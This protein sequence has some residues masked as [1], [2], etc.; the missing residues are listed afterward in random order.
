LRR[1]RR[2]VCSQVR[3]SAV[4]VAR[5]SRSGSPEAVVARAEKC[6]RYGV[7][8]EGVDGRCGKMR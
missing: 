2:A 4:A 3:R 5:R 7:A 6:Q 1:W 8:G